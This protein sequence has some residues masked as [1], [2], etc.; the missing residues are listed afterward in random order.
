M[1]DALV[2]PRAN[3]HGTPLRHCG[4]YSARWLAGKPPWGRRPVLLI[5]DRSAWQGRTS[6]WPA[7]A[8]QG[9]PDRGGRR[10]D[11]RVGSD[12]GFLTTWFLKTS[13]QLWRS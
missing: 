7:M 13:K 8:G 5:M 10:L 11:P 3:R 1:G 9:V 12:T 4:Q 6:S 2:G